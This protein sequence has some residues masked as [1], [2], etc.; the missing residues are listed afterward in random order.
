MAF[1][2][3]NNRNSTFLSIYLF[4]LFDKKDIKTLKSFM[5]RNQKIQVRK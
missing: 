4:I 3:E 2:N 1:V 5:T